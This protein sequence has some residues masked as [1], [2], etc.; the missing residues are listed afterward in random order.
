M[1][2]MD[3]SEIRQVTQVAEPLHAC[4]QLCYILPLTSRPRCNC[5]YHAPNRQ[6]AN[7]WSGKASRAGRCHSR[8]TYRWGPTQKG[9]IDNVQMS[10]PVAVPVC[11]HESCP[12]RHFPGRPILSP[13]VRA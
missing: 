7:D 11:C 6:A 5:C 10:C 4:C 12:L 8:F 2:L 3:S 13:R 1:T 9:K